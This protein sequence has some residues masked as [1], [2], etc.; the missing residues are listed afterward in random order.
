MSAGGTDDQTLGGRTQVLARAAASDPA[1]Y[2]ELFARVMPALQAWLA[3]RTP[4]GRAPDAQDLL[5]EVWLRAL[6]SFS[7]YDPARSFRAWIFG[8]AK[9]VLLQSLARPSLQARSAT[10]SSAPASVVPDPHSSF[11]T[12]LARS[13]AIERFLA[14]VE[15][16]DPD[17]RALLVYCGLEEYSSAQAALRLGITPDAALKR[18]QTLRARL[19]ADPDLNRIVADLFA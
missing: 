1:R 12:R 19:R 16:L 10:D 17:E 7:A 8:I 15:R 11:G 5:Q 2:E 18:W 13:E 6:Q 14:R 9:N 3:L 4:R